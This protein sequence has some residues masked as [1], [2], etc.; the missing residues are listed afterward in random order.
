[1]IIKKVSPQIRG[2]ALGAYAAFF[3]LSLGLTIPI[4]GLIA[5][6]FNYQAVYFF[7]AISGFVAILLLMIRMNK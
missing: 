6:A 4:A 5:G 2:T 1:M 7:G 3:D